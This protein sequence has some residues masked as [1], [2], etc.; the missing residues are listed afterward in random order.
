MNDRLMERYEVRG[1]IFEKVITPREYGEN[2]R[3]ADKSKKINNKKNRRKNK[4]G[5]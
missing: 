3:K 4:C 5:C 1:D 2:F